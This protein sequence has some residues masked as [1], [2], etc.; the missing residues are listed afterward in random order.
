MFSAVS[1]MVFIVNGED[2]V[3]ENN[4]GAGSGTTV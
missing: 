1:E 4:Y 2:Y 3:S